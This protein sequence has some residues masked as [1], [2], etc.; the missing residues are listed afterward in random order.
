MAVSFGGVTYEWSSG[1]IIGLF[2]CSG[3]L[4]ILLGLQQVYAIFT[5][6]SRHVFLVE[7]FKSK[8]MFILFAMTA[9]GGTAIFVLIYMVPIFFQLTRNDT[10]EAAMRLLPFITLMIFA[11]IRNS[12]ILSTYGYYMP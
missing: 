5:T 12:A 2:Y 6:T 10:L 4:F 8:T 1:Q 9:A 3:V 7:F 11:V